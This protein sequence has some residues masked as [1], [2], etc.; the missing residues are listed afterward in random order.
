M[1][2]RFDRRDG[3]AERLDGK[4]RTRGKAEMAPQRLEKID[5]APGNDDIALAVV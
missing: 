1:N 3:G 2:W 5:S 4:T